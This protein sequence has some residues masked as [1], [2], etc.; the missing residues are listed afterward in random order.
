MQRVHFY[1]Q[2]RQTNKT[3]LSEH[4]GWMRFKSLAHVRVNRCLTSSPNK[5]TRNIVCQVEN[6]IK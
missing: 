4:R 1:D 6:K 3:L 5:L 2:D